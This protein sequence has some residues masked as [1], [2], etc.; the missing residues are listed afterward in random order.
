MTTRQICA[1][2]TGS[3]NP[4]TDSMLCSIHPAWVSGDLANIRVTR[5]SLT[6]CAE[7]VSAYRPS[8]AVRM[9][10]CAPPATWLNAGWMGQEGLSATR[11]LSARGSGATR[12][13]LSI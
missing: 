10:H 13:P 5:V 4:V 3:K 8:T 1:V 2:K 11:K 6:E 9:F 7:L 12:G